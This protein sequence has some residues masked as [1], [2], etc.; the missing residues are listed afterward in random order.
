MDTT[1][2]SEQAIESPGPT[3]KAGL[4][5]RVRSPRFFNRHLMNIALL[6]VLPIAFGDSLGTSLGLVQDPDI[7]WHLADAR[8][9]CI[10]HHFIQTE[11][12]SFTV[13]GERWVNPE[14]LSEL[15][16]W[17]GYQLLRLRGLY[18]VTWLVLCANCLLIYWRGYRQSRSADAAFWSACLGFVLM[19]VNAG[20]RMIAI[21]YVALSAEL[22]ILESSER[23]NRRLLW[24]LP[25]LFCLWI[26]L[27]G[28]WAIG[29]ALLVLY[30]VCGLFRVRMGELQQDPLAG[31]ERNRLLL[32][33]AASIAALMI[34]P[35]G[36]RLVWN[37]FDMMLNQNVNIATVKEWQPLQLGTL[38][39]TVVVVIIALMVLANLK[40]G[41]KWKLY[42]LAVV[43]F[44]FYA[45]FD[46][47]RFSFL[48][49]VLVAPALA[50]DLAR[51]FSSDA[52][53]KTIPAM[54]GLVAAGALCFCAFMFP[55]ENA[56]QKKLGLAFP[57]Q[58]I[59]SIEPAWRT[60][61]WDY[62]GGMM[63]FESKPSMI[64]SRLDI[65]EHH[66]ILQRYLAAMNVID[67]L[68]VLDYYRV[69]HVLVQ[70]RQPLSYLL[71]HTA[72]WRLVATEKATP[73]NYVLFARDP[74]AAG[75]G[76]QGSKTPVE[77]IH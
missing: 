55:S 58:I 48:A 14:W 27:H 10:T 49:A 18:V 12:F 54:N 62:V 23:G 59:Q 38:E 17:F 5:A 34:N 72:G 29:M 45:A 69:D 36:W 7:W 25:P 74:V 76:G 33:L 57:V 1:P 66:K 53:T 46:H 30:I 70:G 63:A 19:T 26:N 56:L 13:A 28:S 65:F 16:Y 75:P 73:D 40:C 43:F 52:D 61:N 6:C 3:G 64:D 8:L 11:P 31:G 35:Y 21:G 71:R 15:P 22:L 39:P 41:R 67:S 50:I 68:E 42:E 4:F 77:A 51:S 32:M 9:L 24:L 37:P 2:T 60:L 47:M 44:A 20:P